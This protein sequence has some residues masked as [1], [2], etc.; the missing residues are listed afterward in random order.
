MK[1]QLFVFAG[2][3]LFFL[4]TCSMGK[5]LFISKKRNLPPSITRQEPNNVALFLLWAQVMFIYK[6]QDKAEKERLT[7]QAA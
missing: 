7:P 2:L 3:M 1:K 6:Q 4:N 5:E